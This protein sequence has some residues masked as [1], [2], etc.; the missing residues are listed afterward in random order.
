[1]ETH[2][3][4][5]ILGAGN[6]GGVGRGERRAA[7]AGGGRVALEGEVVEGGLE[8]AILLLLL[9]EVADGRGGVRGDCCG[10]G[11]SEVVRIRMVDVG[12]HVVVVRDPSRVVRHVVGRWEAPGGL[13][14]E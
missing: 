3:P 11:A 1:M 6:V 12:R 5:G 14:R 13:T 8:S 4:R 9:E 10:A 7:G 2:R